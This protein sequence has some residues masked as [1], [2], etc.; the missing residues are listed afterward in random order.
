MLIGIRTQAPGKESRAAAGSIAAVGPDS[1][2]Q[3]GDRAVLSCHPDDDV[4]DTFAGPQDDLVALPP[5][6]SFEAGALAAAMLAAPYRA[7]LS[8]GGLKPTESVGVFACGGR[9]LF[10]LP[11]AVALAAVHIV[12]IDVRS[13]ALDRARRLGAD[14][15]LDP[16]PIDAPGAIRAHNGGRG[17]DLALVMDGAS[18]WLDLAQACL[19]PGGRVVL[20]G[21]G[22]AVALAAENLISSEQAV[23]GAGASDAAD[24]E[25]VLALIA[26]GRLDISGVVPPRFALSDID[27]ARATLD[28]DTP[29][30]LVRP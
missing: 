4:G 11:L 12:G 24:R 6:V 14:L 23:L 2:W 18:E 5:G 27:A 21:A 15:V 26:A 13:A 17:L 28:D 19:A 20:A 30:V 3:A 10:A 1:G 16:R 25:A 9:G 22:G 8:R 29:C 7:L